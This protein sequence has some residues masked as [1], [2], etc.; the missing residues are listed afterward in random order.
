MCKSG[1]IVLPGLLILTLI[2]NCLATDALGDGSPLTPTE[3]QEFLDWCGTDNNWT[4]ASS[5]C[6]KYGFTG[7]AYE[8]CIRVCVEM[9]NIAIDV[10]V[11]DPSSVGVCM[12]CGVGEYFYIDDTSE[13]CNPCDAGTYRTEERHLE[14]SC[15]E[16]PEGTFSPG[17]A[18]SCTSCPDGYYNNMPGASECTK[19]HVDGNGDVAHSSEPRDSIN[20][21]YIE[22]TV[23]QTDAIGTFRHAEDCAIQL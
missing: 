10:V 2:P 4:S 14:G 15:I 21:C 3:C 20:T 22:A 7:T 5:E 13:S 12:P 17:G 16:C 23:E 11:S 1:C 18:A 8:N 19:C 6:T 9:N